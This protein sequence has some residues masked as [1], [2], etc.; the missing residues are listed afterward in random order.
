MKK[1]KIIKR[2]SF[3]KIDGVK[4]LKIKG[5]PY[6]MG[7]QHGYHLADKISLMI[8]RVLPATAGYVSA[9][10]GWSARTAKKMMSKGMKLAKEHFPGFFH[11][12]NGRSQRRSKSCRSRKYHRKK[13][14]SGTPIM[15]SGA[16]TVILI[17]G[18]RTERLL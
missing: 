6:E 1:E 5:T 4:I 2:S 9:Q 13:L 8:T 15:T 3:K 17:T 16:S 7:Y 10:T 11:G 14:C 18:Y 12:R